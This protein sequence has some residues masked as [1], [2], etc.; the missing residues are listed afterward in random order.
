MCVDVE[1]HSSLIMNGSGHTYEWVVSHIWMSHGAPINESGHTYEGVISHIWMSS[2]T[3]MNESFQKYEWVRSHIW[4]SHVKHMDESGHTYQWV[5]SHIWMSHITH[6]NESYHTYEWVT[7]HT[8][9]RTQLVT[10]LFTTRAGSMSTIVAV[11]GTHFHFLS[12]SFHSYFLSY[13][14]TAY[15]IW[16]VFSWISN[17][18]PIALEVSF[19]HLNHLECHFFNLESQSIIYVSRNVSRSFGH[20][21]VK[22]D[23]GDWDWRFRLNDTPNAI[24]CGTIHVSQLIDKCLVCRSW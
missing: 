3:H 4:M 17:L 2:V 20:V 1:G 9:A 12:I 23:Q 10:C 8:D 24:G 22:R 6:M 19:L 5:W 15:C 16:S 18:N 21:P 14:S 7:F 13:W 11:T